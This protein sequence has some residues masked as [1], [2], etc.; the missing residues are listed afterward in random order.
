MRKQGEG[1]ARRARKA[2]L[3]RAEAKEEAL[4]Q[5]AYSSRREQLT[6]LHHMARRC[7]AATLSEPCG[8]VVDEAG[9]PNGAEHDLGVVLWCNRT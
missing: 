5:Q 8:A 7:G 6:L 9:R 1:V 3:A 4:A 2:A